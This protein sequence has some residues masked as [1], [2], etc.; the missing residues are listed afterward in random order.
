MK[1]ILPP[2][3]F[4]LSENPEE[5]ITKN[6]RAILQK[7]GTKVYVFRDRIELRSLI[8]TQVIARHQGPNAQR[9]SQLSIRQGEGD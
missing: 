6:M 5:A 4:S 8:P 1:A 3:G 9:E 2:E 7:F